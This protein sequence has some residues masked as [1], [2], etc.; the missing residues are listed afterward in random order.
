MEPTPPHALEELI[1]RELSKLPD[2]PAP[3]D[4]IPKVLAKI[5]ARERRRWWQRPWIQWPLAAQAASVPVLCASVAA[6]LL[7]LSMLWRVVTAQLVVESLSER[8]DS[9]SA[10][11]DVFSAL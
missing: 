4:L 6:A 1:H 2:R 10:V 3:T 9:V 7:G 11:W 5:A 8:W